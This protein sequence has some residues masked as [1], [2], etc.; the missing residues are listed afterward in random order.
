[1]MTTDTRDRPGQSKN[2]LLRWLPPDEYRRF[3]ADLEVV[4]LERGVELHGVD[5]EIKYVYFVT[6]GV[7]SL[8]ATGPDGESVAAAAR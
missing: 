2:D 8:V 7:A 5:E 4:K 1:M 3:A 6:E